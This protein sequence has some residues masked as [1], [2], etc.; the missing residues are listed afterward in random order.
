MNRR[1]ALL[2]CTLLDAALPTM[3]QARPFRI[4]M[5]LFRGE[6]AVEKGFRNY[7]AQHKLPVEFIVRNIA[8]DTSQIPALIAEARSLEVDLIYTWGTPVTLAVV[9]SHKDRDPQ[10]HVTDIPVLFTMVS[11]PEGSGIVKSRNASGRNFTGVVHVVPLEQQLGAIRAYLPLKRMAII[12]NPAEINSRLNVTELRK[13]AAHDKFELIELAIPLDTSGKPNVGALPGLISQAAT[14]KPD[15]LYL[16][17]DT[18]LAANR[19]VFTAAAIEARLP[20][21]S[22]TEAALRDGQALFGLVSRYENVGLLAGHK[23]EQILMGKLAPQDITIDSL[24]RFSY[25]V[26]MAAAKKLDLY[27]PL[28]VA[29]YAEIIH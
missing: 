5:I 27:P 17:P 7:L 4:Y 15:L 18:F 20:I 9:G 21:F 10:I 14:H 12:Y 2:V 8:Q 26:N 28:K 23:A 6:T 13:A 25:V 19:K 16:G 24:L 1:R 3:A 22:A 29:N 11:S